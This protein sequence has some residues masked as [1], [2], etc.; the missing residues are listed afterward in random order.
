VTP[1]C[2]VYNLGTTFATYSVRMRIGSSYNQTASVTR[3]VPGQ[4]LYLTFPAWTASPVGSISV[5]CSTEY[6]SDIQTSNDK[7]T[8]TVTVLRPVIHD[9]GCTRIIAPSGIVD[10][11]APVTP[12]AIVRSF[13]NVTENFFVRFKIGGFYTDSQPATL[14]AGGTDTVDFQGWIAGP[15]GT[16]ITSCSTMLASD[17]NRAN[18]RLTDS[19]RVVP[20]TTVLEPLISAARPLTPFLSVS[21]NPFRTQTAIYYGLPSPACVVLGIYSSNGRLVQTLFQGRQ[22]AGYYSLGI[23]SLG[24]RASRYGRG[25]YYV[26]LELGAPG[27]GVIRKLVKI[28]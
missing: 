28:E 16:H 24:F 27:L 9:V 13:G 4:S 18:D 10:S 14:I 19:V 3:H 25:V 6:S 17:V 21:P 22:Q 5:R 1:A 15:L 2:S 12:Q 8:G 7:Q 20:L 11:E 26:R 23:S